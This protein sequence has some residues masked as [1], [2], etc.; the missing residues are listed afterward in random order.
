MGSELLQEAAGSQASS[1]G[2]P[3]ILLACLCSGSCAACVCP[4]PFPIIIYKLFCGEKRR[5][6]HVCLL[7]VCWYRNLHNSGSIPVV[8][9]KRSKN[10]IEISYVHR[11][12][13][14]CPPA[15][16][17]V[18]PQWQQAARASRLPVAPS[19]AHRHRNRASDQKSGWFGIC[20]KHWCRGWVSFVRHKLLSINNFHLYL[21]WA[22]TRYPHPTLHPLTLS[23][24]FNFYSFFLHFSSLPTVHTRFQL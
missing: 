8:H 12:C 16:A 10:H 6:K 21:Y 1:E 5:Y 3:W 15:R 11:C 22:N 13:Q 9:R 19:P 23:A 7:L 4:W 24:S 17:H 14:G 18:D 20:C 2:W